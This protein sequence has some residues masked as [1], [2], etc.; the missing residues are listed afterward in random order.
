[1]KKKLLAL[2]FA[3]AMA[4]TPALAAAEPEGMDQVPDWAKDAM[5]ECS[6]LDMLADETFEELTQPVTQEQ[7]DRIT[8]SM[9]AKL[10]L[11]GLEPADP[12]AKA[13]LVD[14]T[15]QGVM[16]AF[17]QEVSAYILH[18]VTD[19]PIET[20]QNLKVVQGDGTG[21]A[22]DRVCTLQEALIMGQRLVL[23]VYDQLGC[24]S[25]GLLWKATGNGNTL[26]LL[27]TIHIET[28][29]LYPVHA[30]LRNA[31]LSSDVVM[32]EVD[33]ADEEDM[34]R[35][36]ELQLYDDGTTL[37]DHISP[38]LHE[39]V[40]AALEPLGL[41]QEQIDSYRAWALAST[42][43]Q[44][45]VSDVDETDDGVFPIDL[46]VQ[47]KAQENNIPLT[48]VESA[49]FQ[50]EH[51]MNPLT[52]EFQEVYLATALDS[53]LNADG[54]AG[55]PEA[56]EQTDKMMAAWR[57]AD[58]A[59]LEAILDKDAIMT[60]DDEMTRRLFEERDPNMVAFADNFL[61]SETPTTGFMAVGAGH[62]VGE[63]GIVQSLKDLG[64]TVEFLYTR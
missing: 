8:D 17:Y 62:M 31:L 30:T 29:E 57:F 18:G 14:N 13:V 55:D 45:A 3:L 32:T 38:E 35:M 47:Y 49:T 15:R 23:C 39:K 25:M 56:V 33:F 58:V 60:S 46:Y 64:Y 12:D 59:G 22:L 21:L 11:L 7:M 36:A 43:L 10:A 37:A 27:G 6:A 5:L 48:A 42:F 52:D 63:T 28:D 20:L 19:D 34:A 51:V 2:L 26:Y 44:L 4:V 61:K 50:I 16:N 1:M 9:A 53:Y 40:L 41:T 54:S 24:G